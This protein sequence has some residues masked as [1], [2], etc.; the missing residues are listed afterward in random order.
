[1]YVRQNY[2]LGMPLQ[3]R[4]AKDKFTEL[5]CMSDYFYLFLD[6]EFRAN[7]GSLGE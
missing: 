4:I 5:F 1:M 3:G 2:N 6:K 7:K